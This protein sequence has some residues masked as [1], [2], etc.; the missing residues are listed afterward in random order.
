MT[1]RR[2]RKRGIEARCKVGRRWVS[3]AV[4]R[5]VVLL[6]GS[7]VPAFAAWYDPGW[8]YQQEITILPTLADSDLSEFPYL[9]K[10][11]D[12]ANPPEMAATLGRLMD[13]ER[14]S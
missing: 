14:S 12:A 3:F 2:N 11:T 5:R 6:T 4:C 10:I 8:T 13:W 9:V 1:A 7:A